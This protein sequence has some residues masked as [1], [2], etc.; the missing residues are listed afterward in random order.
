MMNEYTYSTLTQESQSNFQIIVGSQ[1]F[2]DQQLKI[3]QSRLPNNF[4]LSQNYPNPFNPQTT[5]SYQLPTN[6]QVT[7]KIYDVLG[8]EVRTLVN[9][10]KPAGNHLIVWDGKN[11]LG[12]NVG[13]GIYFYQLQLNNNILYANKMLLIK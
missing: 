2:V 6:A 4:S 10:N 12:E 3:I 8:N 5:I 1:N 13:T 9:G 11:N 7:I